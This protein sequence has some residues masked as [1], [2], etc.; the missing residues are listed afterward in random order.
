MKI[1][2]AIGIL[3]ASVVALSFVDPEDLTKALTAMT[4]GFGQLLGAMAILTAVAKSTGFI[5]IP[6]IAASLILLA[7]AILIL[8]AAVVIFSNLIG[9]NCSRVWLV[10][11]SF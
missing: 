8:S 2:I 7:R 6:L 3:T 9:M 1:A 10:L 4:I 11:E 5:K